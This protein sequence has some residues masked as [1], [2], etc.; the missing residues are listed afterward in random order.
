VL[1][2]LCGLLFSTAGQAD[3]FGVDAGRNREAFLKRIGSVIE[4][5]LFYEHLSDTENLRMHL[6]YLAN[7]ANLAYL[8]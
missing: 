4:V 6:A 8:D 5:P 2:L 3:V 1:K 7:L